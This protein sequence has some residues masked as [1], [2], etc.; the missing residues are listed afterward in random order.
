MKPRSSS[1]VVKPFT[2]VTRGAVVFI[3]AVVIDVLQID[4]ILL[5]DVGRYT[6][7]VVAVVLVAAEDGRRVTAQADASR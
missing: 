2:V 1:S 4:A 3:F 7:A 6:D 5:K